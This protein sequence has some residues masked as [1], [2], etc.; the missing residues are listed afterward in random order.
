MIW[1]ASGWWAVVRT[2]RGRTGWAKT[3]R[4]AEAPVTL[5]LPAAAGAGASA[6]PAGIVT[7]AG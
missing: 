4:I 5:S 7:A 2:L 3:D 6:M 1:Y